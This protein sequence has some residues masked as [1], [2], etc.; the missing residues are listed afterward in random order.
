MA[1]KTT[2]ALSVAEMTPAQ[3]LAYAR[4]MAAAN[5]APQ[6]SAPRASVK[7][8]IATVY[9]EAECFVPDVKALVALKRAERAAEQERL[10]RSIG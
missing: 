4:A 5:H 3:R 6:T 10:L 8:A 1:T 7:E 9:V 2:K